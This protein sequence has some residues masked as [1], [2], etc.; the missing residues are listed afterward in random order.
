MSAVAEKMTMFGAIA[1]AETDMRR[2]KDHAWLLYDHLSNERG[3][4][5]QEQI[6]LS[7]VAADLLQAGE[8]LGKHCDALY[9]ATK[10]SDASPAVETSPI[11][12]PTRLSV[13]GLFSLFDALGTVYDLL[14]GMLSQ[15]RFAKHDDPHSL[16]D[17]GDMLE[18]LQDLIAHAKGSL[19]KEAI[20][21]PP[22]VKTAARLVFFLAEEWVDGSSGPD[23]ALKELTKALA[24]LGKA[25]R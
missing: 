14:S 16:N 3:I 7:W 8:A 18:S 4:D 19:R 2:V 22:T 11:F 9:A 12:D 25:V 13:D 20:S 15:P 5:K 1:D 17:A 24:G 10:S 6:S 23:I 21:R